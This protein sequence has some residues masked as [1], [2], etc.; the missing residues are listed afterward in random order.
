MFSYYMYI[1]YTT[2]I[3]KCT[4][5]TVQMKY[6]ISEDNI[7]LLQRV[8]VIFQCVVVVNVYSR[9]IS[10]PHLPILPTHGQMNAQIHRWVHMHVGKCACTLV[11][12]CIVQKDDECVRWHDLNKFGVQ[13]V[14]RSFQLMQRYACSVVSLILRHGRWLVLYLT[15]LHAWVRNV[16]YVL[17]ECEQASKVNC[18]D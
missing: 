17:I 12:A 4:R 2:N 10:M 13:V 9:V 11:W 15:L 5:S 14:N 6:F 1:R 7:P 8:H 18:G 3:S 16:L